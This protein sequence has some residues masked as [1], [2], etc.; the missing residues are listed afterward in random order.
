MPPFYLARVAGSDSLRVRFGDDWYPL[1]RLPRGGGGW[2]WTKEESSLFVDNPGAQTRRARVWFLARSLVE[3]DLQVW[4]NGQLRATVHV[5]RE[6]E[7]V[8]IPELEIA[9]G[10]NH[11]ALRSSAPAQ[12]PGPG[13]GRLLGTAVYGLRLELRPLENP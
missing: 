7:D 10:V 13:D 5:G 9:P 11:W 6:I 8:V 1:E 12:S 3:R 4:I 2:R